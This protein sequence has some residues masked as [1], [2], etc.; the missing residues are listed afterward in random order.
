MVEPS[1]PGFWKD[2]GV[3]TTSMRGPTN[4]PC[5][6]FVLLMGITLRVDT[7]PSPGDSGAGLSFW[8]ARS[9]GG[10]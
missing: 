7:V 3:S 8:A 5:T 6:G 10:G 2:S 4:C 1:T 9:R